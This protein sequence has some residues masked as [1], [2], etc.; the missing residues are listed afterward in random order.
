MFNSC[1][2]LAVTFGPFTGDVQV[3][4]LG[5]DSLLRIFIPSWLHVL[6]AEDEVT[7]VQM[8]LRPSSISPCQSSFHFI[9]IFIIV[10][11]CHR[12]QWCAI[13]LTRQHVIS[14]SVFYVGGFFS[15][16]ELCGLQNTEVMMITTATMV[17]INPLSRWLICYCEAGSC[18]Q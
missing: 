13:P 11:I 2:Q 8:F 15:L 9:I 18:C 6:F 12:P 3:W 14:F 5:T 7:L 17:S 1:V 16:A 10:I 4:V